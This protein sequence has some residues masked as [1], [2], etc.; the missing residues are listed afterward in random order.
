MIK[1]NPTT[2]DN[3]VAMASTRANIEVLFGWVHAKVALIK[4]EENHYVVEGSGNWSE[5]AKYEQYLLG[6]NKGLFDFRKEL[7]ELTQMRWKAVKGK[8]VKQG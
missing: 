1:R 3:L 6:N 8:L 2:I 4:T 5:N 7:F